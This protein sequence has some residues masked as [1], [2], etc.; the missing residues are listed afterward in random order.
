MLISNS[1]YHGKIELYRFFSRWNEP[2]SLFLSILL[3]LII[4]KNYL[5]HVKCITEE[6][7]K[8]QQNSDVTFQ[9]TIKLMKIS[10]NSKAVGRLTDGRESIFL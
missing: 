9:M 5:S 7:F 10:K 8:R 6:T 1:L 3:I 2:I 4:N